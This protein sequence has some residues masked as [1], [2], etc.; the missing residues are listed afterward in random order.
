RRAFL[1]TDIEGR[2][3]DAVVSGHGIFDQETDPGLL[4]VEMELLD[5]P[6]DSD[7][8]RATTVANPHLETVWTDYG[9]T[10][11]VDVD[12]AEVGWV[13][14]GKPV[15]S[16]FGMQWK[17]GRMKPKALPFS[18]ENVAGALEWS[19]RRLTIHSLHGWHGETYMN[20]VGGAQGKSAYI[21]TEVA[22]GQPWHLHLGQLQVIK[23]Q[24]NEELQRALPESVAKVLKSFAV[25]GPVNIELGLD[26]KG[27][28][29]PGLVTAQWE[30]LIRL[31]Q[32]DLVA[33]V[34]LQDVS[35]TVRL[36]DGQWN[37]S[38]VMVDGYLEL[39]SVTLFDLPLTGVKG[40]F[41]VD[42][43]EILLGSKGQ[44]EESEFHERNVYRNRR[45]AADLFDG[46][47]GMLA[48]ILLDTEDESQTQY[49]VDVK[50]ENA[51]LG[52]WA[53][54]RRLQRE[55]LSGKVNGEVTMT[56]MGTS[57]TNTLGEGW[58]QIT[59]AQLYELP[60]FAQIFAFINFRQPDDTAF[61]YAF[62]EFGI[63]D[64]LIDFGNIELVGD[65]LKLKGRG[66][67]GYAGP[68]QS[69]LALDFYTKATNRVPILRP[70]IEKFGSNWVRIQVVGTVNSPIPLVQPRIPL[71][72]DAFQGFMQAV[73][74]GQRR[75][76]PRP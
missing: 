51:E 48:L 30:S 29:T 64:G 19:D 36:V 35:G 68:Q 49:R 17:N 42:G 37:G 6:I 23:V 28:D 3:G 75:P 20:V 24:A 34:D 73:D 54:S 39:D 14:G 15:V 63:H 18:W 66:V 72:D 53:K 43:E 52:E 50:V 65:T 33:G 12:R 47:V 8:R 61:N 55:R 40:P 31:Q 60:V 57:A 21:E 67:V 27:W 32:N 38:R 59:P 5:V 46:R 26:M 2:H 10:G 71:L 22:P 4:A 70:L 7:L 25:Q 44:G 11:T 45:M 74:N 62:G 58:V 41:R 69:N 13:P 1:F 76:V 16:L 9:L 56:G